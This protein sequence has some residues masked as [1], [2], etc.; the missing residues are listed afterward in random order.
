MI[1]VVYHFMI[2]KMDSGVRRVILIKNKMCVED[3]ST[4]LL[5][6]NKKGVSTLYIHGT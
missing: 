3:V 6:L 5:S 4:L 2:F 1:K